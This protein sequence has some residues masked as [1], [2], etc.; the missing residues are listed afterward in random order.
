MKVSKKDLRE[1]Y[2]QMGLIECQTEVQEKNGT[3]VFFDDVVN[4]KFI[5]RRY[6]NP[7]VEYFSTKTN[8]VQSYDILKDV[9]IQRISYKMIYAIPSIQK[10]QI[11]GVKDRT[12]LALDIFQKLIK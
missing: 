9:D 5:F 10:R 3:L 1:L 2:R 11:K 8:S 12:K 7:R 6:S 4:C